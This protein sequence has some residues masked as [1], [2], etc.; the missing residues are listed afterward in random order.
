MVWL[1]GVSR[2]RDHPL[3]ATSS[4]EV[5][6]AFMLLLLLTVACLVIIAPLREHSFAG[7]IPAKRPTGPRTNAQHT[8]NKD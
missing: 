5:K 6:A 4:E 1:I 3:Q 7:E 2:E 8:V